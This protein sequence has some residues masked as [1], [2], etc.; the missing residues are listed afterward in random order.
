MK[1]VRHTECTSHQGTTFTG[2]VTLDSVL[3]GQDGGVTPTER[4][5]RDDDRLASS[6]WLKGTHEELRDV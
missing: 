4:K 6:S 3:A 2:N 5:P 1:V